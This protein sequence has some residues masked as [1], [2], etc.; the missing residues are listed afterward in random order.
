MTNTMLRAAVMRRHRGAAIS[1]MRNQRKSSRR[2]RAAASRS[3]GSRGKGDHP[4]PAVVCC[5]F[6]DTRHLRL[7]AP[8]RSA[9]ISGTCPGDGSTKQRREARRNGRRPGWVPFQCDAARH[10][11]R[12]IFW[13]SPRLRPPRGWFAASGAAWST[14]T[15]RTCAARSRRS[16]CWRWSGMVARMR[17]KLRAWSRVCRRRGDAV[18]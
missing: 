7:V 1:L 8:N 12:R 11:T 10:S 18:K 9:A 13:Y 2:L 15:S 5:L 16:G 4:P 3:S 14:T 17:S 6:H